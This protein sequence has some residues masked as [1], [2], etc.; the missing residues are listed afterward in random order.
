MD[1]YIHGCYT[2]HAVTGE[3][4]FCGAWSLYNFLGPSLRTGK[5]N[6]KYEIRSKVNIYLEWENITTNY[7]IKKADKCHKRHKIQKNNIIS[8]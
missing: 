2:L 8:P 7:K 4:K 3:S 5:Q 6:Y 1:F